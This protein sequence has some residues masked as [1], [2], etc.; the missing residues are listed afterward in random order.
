MEDIGRDADPRSEPGVADCADDIG[1]EADPRSD[2]DPH[3]AAPILGS[4]SGS[5]AIHGSSLKLGP[6]RARIG[7]LIRSGVA[8]RGP[9]RAADP[10]RIGPN[11][12]VMPRS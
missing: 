3:L 2:P 1:R 9:D 6:D 8:G 10:A 12:T 7:R 5:E 11:R 4:G